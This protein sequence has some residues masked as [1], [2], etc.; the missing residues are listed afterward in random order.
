MKKRVV[1]FKDIPV[2]VADPN[3][4]WGR[5]PKRA[6]IHH[7]QKYHSLMKHIG[8]AIKAGGVV[9]VSFHPCRGRILTKAG[10]IIIERASGMLTFG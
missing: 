1:R 3:T 2:R 8:L 9:D 10:A 7:T 5:D 4:R 6:D